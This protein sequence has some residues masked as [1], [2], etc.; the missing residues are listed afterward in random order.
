LHNIR[1]SLLR[2]ELPGFHIDA[3]LISEVVISTEKFTQDIIDVRNTLRENLSYRETLSYR[4]K[5]PS[6]REIL[7][8]KTSF[9]DIIRGANIKKSWSA[10]NILLLRHIPDKRMLIKSVNDFIR[11]DDFY[12]KLAQRNSYIYSCIRNNHLIDDN[13][14]LKL[15]KKCLELSEDALE[16]IDWSTYIK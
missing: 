10:L 5:T 13:D 15:N 2:L 12:S 11:L 7:S 8:Q 3:K 4:D 14:F 6:Y 1:D 9:Y 16:K